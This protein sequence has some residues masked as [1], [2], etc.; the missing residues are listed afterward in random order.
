MSEGPS[1]DPVCPKHPEQ[2]DFYL[3]EGKKPRCKACVS[4]KRKAWTASNKGKASSPPPPVDAEAEQAEQAA[5]VE[6]TKAPTKRRDRFAGESEE[7]IRRRKTLRGLANCQSACWLSL[8]EQE[9]QDK[10]FQEYQEKL[11]KR[12]GH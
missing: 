8:E 6:P 3:Y 12:H 2:K 11:A 5:P 9:A 4:E 1:S 7:L 10:W